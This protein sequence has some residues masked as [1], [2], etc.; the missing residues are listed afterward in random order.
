MLFARDIQGP[1]SS[2]LKQFDAAVGKNKESDM[3]SFAVFLSEDSD[4]ME[5]K[6]KALVEKEKISENVPL[7]IVEDIA[8]PPAFKIA[9]DAE[10]TVLLYTK[11]KVVSNFAFKSGEM[12]D[13]H[14]KAIL[15]QLPK[16]LPSEEELK[17]K[18]EA[19]ERAKKVADEL[20]KSEEEKKDKK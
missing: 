6:I 2:L 19:A 18:R 3:R 15:A 9:K 14:V 7:T 12:Q 17:Q 5:G 8:G 1:L 16:I 10:V 20:K 4:E 13:K 11:G